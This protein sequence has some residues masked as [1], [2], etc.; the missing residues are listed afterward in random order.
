M[1][2][3]TDLEGE[4]VSRVLSCHERR[5]S[6]FKLPVQTSHVIKR[7]PAPPLVASPRDECQVDDTPTTPHAVKEKPLG[8][9]AD[10]GRHL[11]KKQKAE[12]K[13]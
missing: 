8:G 11:K 10:R 13:R 3:S 5:R 4:G 2:G 9:D 6:V 7:R 1:V 12:M